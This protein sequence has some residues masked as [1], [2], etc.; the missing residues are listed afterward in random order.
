[1]LAALRQTET[2]RS[3]PLMSRFPQETSRV[4]RLGNMSSSSFSEL[5]THALESVQKKANCLNS[6][7]TKSLRMDFCTAN[8]QIKPPARA[9][10][11]HMLFLSSLLTPTA[12]VKYWQGSTKTR[13]LIYFDLFMSQQ[14]RS[15]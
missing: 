4:A 7:C 6:K 10:T 8:K 13:A 5:P 2:C 12:A 11:L 9:V 15:N 3:L 14:E 1:M